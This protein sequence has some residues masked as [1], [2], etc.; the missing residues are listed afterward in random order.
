M[1]SFTVK[2]V[3]EIFQYSCLQFA[4]WAMD[5]IVAIDRSLTVVIYG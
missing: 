2:M 3:L 4:S 5:S 1:L